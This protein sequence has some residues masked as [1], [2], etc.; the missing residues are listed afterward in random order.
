MIER[1]L[2]TPQ[3]SSAGRLFDAAAAL[4]D[5]C[6]EATFEGEAGMAMEAAAEA[7]E[8]AAAG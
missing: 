3:T 7:A 1:G 2:N 6:P 4:L 8:P 5:L